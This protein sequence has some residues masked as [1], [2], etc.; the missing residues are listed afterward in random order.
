LQPKWQSFRKKLVN[1]GYETNMIF[2]NK[3]IVLYYWLHSGTHH[4]NLAIWG[5][6]LHENNNKLYIYALF[7]VKI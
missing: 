1:F 5:K 2:L 7:K 4:K 6:N 3:W